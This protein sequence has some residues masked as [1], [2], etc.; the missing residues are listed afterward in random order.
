VLLVLTSVA[1]ISIHY[2]I[3]SISR[4]RHERV[5]AS[6]GEGV[7]VS[8]RVRVGSGDR[9]QRSRGLPRLTFFTPKNHGSS[10]AMTRGLNAPLR[11]VMIF[12]QAVGFS[13]GD[14]IQM[15]RRNT[16]K[17]WPACAARCRI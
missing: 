2:M 8:G 9:F 5:S 7:K 12:F 6:A 16:C 3:P 17:C 10:M 13:H 4:A 11:G 15:R 1:D 14:G